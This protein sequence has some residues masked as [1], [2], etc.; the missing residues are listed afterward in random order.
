MS[1][2]SART[3]ALKADARRLRS[4]KKTFVEIATLLGISRTHARRL[5]NGTAW[6]KKKRPADGGTGHMA[7][8]RLNDEAARLLRQIPAD[9][10]GVTAYLCGDPLPGRSALDRS[11]S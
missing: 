11:A 3:D 10:R 5:V 1:Q 2:R 6:T 9:T 7:S 4:E 8:R